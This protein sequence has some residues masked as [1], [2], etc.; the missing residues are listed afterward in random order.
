MRAADISA[1]R[2]TIRVQEKDYDLLFN[3][4]AAREAEFVYEACYGH[5]AGYLRIVAH[6]AEQRY[7][8]LAAITYGALAAAQQ[9]AGASVMPFAVFDKLFD[10]AA[11]LHHYSTIAEGIAAALPEAPKKA[12]GLQ[13]DGTEKCLGRD[14]GVVRRLR[15]WTHN[16]FG[17]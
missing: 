14:Y 6:V 3:N 12:E 7:G 15:A 8:A 2:R 1:P 17:G 5:S 9:E 10:Y 16:R 13:P 4:A 11:L